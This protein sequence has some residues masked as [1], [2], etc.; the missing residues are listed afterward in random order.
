MIVISDGEAPPKT[1]RVAPSTV[2]FV[3]LTC[4][5]VFIPPPSLRAGKGGGGAGNIWPSVKYI[6]SCFFKQ[7]AGH[8]GLGLSRAMAVH[9][10]WD[11]ERPAGRQQACC[12]KWL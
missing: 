3:R 5:V 6:L 7:L 10:L 11:P 12:D 4:G 1:G 2:V 9:S 8:K